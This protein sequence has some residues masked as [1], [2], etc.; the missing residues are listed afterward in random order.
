LT[1]HAPEPA[2]SGANIA[3]ESDDSKR[4]GAKRQQQSWGKRASAA[5]APEPAA[6]GADI[7]IE[8]DK[9]KAV[10]SEATRY[11]DLKF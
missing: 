2:A 8:S 4:F 10:W 3:I 11:K 9:L 6:S 5:H 1:A 7:A